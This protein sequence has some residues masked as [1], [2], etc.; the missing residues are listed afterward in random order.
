MSNRHFKTNG[1]PFK[2]N[3]DNR[4]GMGEASWEKSSSERSRDMD[5][6]W[7]AASA[8]DA[9]DESSHMRTLIAISKRRGTFAGR[10]GA[11]EDGMFRIQSFVERDTLYEGKYEDTLA[12]LMALPV[13]SIAQ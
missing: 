12:Y 9:R 4:G 11:P 8:A 10:T 13:K 7:A 6:A 1:P 2:T 5:K 3:T